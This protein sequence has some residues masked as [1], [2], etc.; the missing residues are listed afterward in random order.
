MDIKQTSPGI[1]AYQA[2][3]E[4]AAG[5]YEK[6]NS[7]TGDVYVGDHGADTELKRLLSTRHVTMIALGSSIGMG[8]WLGSGTPSQAAVRPVFFSATSSPSLGYGC[9][10]H[11]IAFGE[12]EVVCSSIKP[13]WVFMVIVSMIVLSAG[14]GNYSA[15]GF[16]YWRETPFTNGFKGFLSVMP[17]RIFAMAG[18][19]DCGLVAAERAN[20]KKLV[21]RAAGS[22]WLR[23]ALFYLLSSL[24]VTINLSPYHPDLFGGEAPTPRP[25]SSLTATAARIRLPT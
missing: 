7:I 11:S 22:I 2:S 21:P 15:V 16:R 18:S 25:S 8:L 20:P 13:L 17:T 24:G 14:G 12:T 10:S 9:V 4:P 19:E 1:A 5:V 3:E 6:R 23:L